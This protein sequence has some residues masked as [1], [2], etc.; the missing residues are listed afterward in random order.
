MDALTF[1]PT[2]KHSELNWCSLSELAGKKTKQEFF[3][4][5]NLV[6]SC[7]KKKEK[8]KKRR[9][10]CR[11]MKD[12]RNRKQAGGHCWR[13]D[14][15]PLAH[16]FVEWP[17]AETHLA[18]ELLSY[19]PDTW[20]KWFLRFVGCLCAFPEWNTPMFFVMCAF[21]ILCLYVV[22]LKQQMSEHAFLNVCLK[23]VTCAKLN[24][25][26]HPA[27]VYNRLSYLC[28]CHWAQGGVHPGQNRQFIA[29][30]AS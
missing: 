20:T 16:W 10:T 24:S 23:L 2:T 28:S 18:V 11:G 22:L 30:L 1:Y 21:F 19:G 12:R 27:I 29:G 9:I 5:Y 3:F 7:C 4:F 15:M 6:I 14:V 13:H 25:P 8:R 17:P 26:I